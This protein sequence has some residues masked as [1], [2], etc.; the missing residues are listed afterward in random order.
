MGIFEC[1]S[2][3]MFQSAL[4]REREREPG[5]GGNNKKIMEFTEI[6]WGSLKLQDL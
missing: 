2:W 6:M 3:A 4:M 5:D 1:G